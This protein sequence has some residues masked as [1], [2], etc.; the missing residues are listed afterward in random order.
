MKYPSAVFSFIT[1]P[2]RIE[3]KDGRTVITHLQKYSHFGFMIHWPF[4]FHFW[5]FWKRQFIDDGIWR[6]GTEK[7]IYF[8][9]PGYRWDYDLGMIRTNGYFGGHWD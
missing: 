8:R 5:L 3:T 6:P 4:G 7:G 1:G 9:L 2:V